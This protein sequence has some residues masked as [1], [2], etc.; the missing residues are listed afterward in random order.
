MAGSSDLNLLKSWNPKLQKNR[1]SVRRKEEDAIEEERKIQQKQK[2][3]ELQDLASGKSKT[4]LE[5]M[6]D[7]AKHLSETKPKP[8]QKPKLVEKDATSKGIPKI[9]KDKL[10]KDDP[11][12]KFKVA[13]KRSGKK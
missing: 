4:G 3:K 12:T 13:K 6:Y 11:M 10:A 8:K 5:W 7:D 2:E 9:N 1:Q